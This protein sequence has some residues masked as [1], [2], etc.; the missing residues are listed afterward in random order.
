MMTINFIM[1]SISDAHINKRISEFM[2]KGYDVRLYGF[3]RNNKNTY[4]Q[5]IAVIGSFSNTLPYL[6]RVAIYYKGIR[7]LFKNNAGNSGIW[8]YQGL[9]VALFAILFNKNKRYI[10]EECDLVHTNVHNVILRF[11][12][13]WFDKRIIA[14][15][16]K[17]VLTSEGFVEYHYGNKKYKKDNI[18]IIPNKLSPEII[19]FPYEA[20]KNYNNECIRFAF[21]GGVR[22]KSLLSIA[23]AIAR[24]FPNHEFHFYGFISPVIPEKELPKNS[25]IFYHGSFKSPNDLSEIYSNVDVVVSTYDTSSPNVKYAEPN[26]LYESMYFRCPILVSRNTFLEKKVLHL[27]IGYSVDPYNQDDIINT[28]KLIEKDYLNKKKALELIKQADVLDEN[29]VDKILK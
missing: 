27:G 17:T 4:K 15:S 22:Y 8:Y 5:G 26:K 7:E 9:D 25:N 6:K 1:N 23:E 16:L 24:N 28:V 2:Q 14:N 3:D 10:Y 12:L 21:I 13:E 11:I 20:D 19:N 29:N 18:V